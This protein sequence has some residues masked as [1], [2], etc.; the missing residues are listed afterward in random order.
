MLVSF[1]MVMVMATVM[2]M[3]ITAGTSA[4]TPEVP[5]V[6]AGS[7]FIGNHG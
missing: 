4:A 6:I 3:V 2:V 5:V 1:S 7:L